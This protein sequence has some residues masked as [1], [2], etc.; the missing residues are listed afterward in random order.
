MASRESL[1]FLL[2][3]EEAK[4]VSI[5]SLRGRGKWINIF[6]SLFSRV[7]LLPLLLVVV[8]LGILSLA[9]NGYLQLLA[10]AFGAAGIIYPLHLLQGQ[11]IGIGAYTL[12]G[13]RVGGLRLRVKSSSRHLLVMGLFVEEEW[14][15]QGIAAF[16]F[17][18]LIA[19][20]AQ[21]APLVIIPINPTH[22]AAKK[23]VRKYFPDGKLSISIP[24]LVQ[25]PFREKLFGEDS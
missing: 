25:H 7:V 20:S 16:L 9:S 21:E 15:K 5:A 14:R 22:P 6:Y 1:K 10:L 18:E 8:G 24:L 13:E 4:Y 19:L 23:L 2:S 11:V 3:K 12:D 17:E